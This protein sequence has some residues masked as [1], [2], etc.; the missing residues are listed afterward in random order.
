[1]K[2]TKTEKKQPTNQDLL[3]AMACVAIKLDTVIEL[4]D[5]VASLAEKKAKGQLSYVGQ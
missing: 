5:K 1:M 4:M 2:N 3:N